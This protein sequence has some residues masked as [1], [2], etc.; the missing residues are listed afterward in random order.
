M[1]LDLTDSVN[2]SA[3]F[4]G[5]LSA[6]DD[7][8]GDLLPSDG[9][10]VMWLDGGYLEVLISHGPTALPKK[11][12]L[13]VGKVGAARTALRRRSFEPGRL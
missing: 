1:L 11:V 5:A 4:S 10:S 3:D 2:L 13:P 12:T 6:L 8:V 9:I 7:R